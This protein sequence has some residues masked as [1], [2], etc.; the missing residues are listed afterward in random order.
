M[1]NLTLNSS[2]EE[3]EAYYPYEVW[4]DLMGFTK[5]ID[6][7][8]T[9]VQP[10]I[11]VCGFLMNLISFRVLFGLQFK[12]IRLFKYLKVYILNSMAVC[13]ISMFI[14]LSTM[15][16]INFNSYLSIGYT[17]YIYVIIVNTGYFY[18]CLLDILIILEQILTL[19]NKINIVN[20]YS[21]F[22]FCLMAF[23]LCLLINLPY[24]FVFKPA[25]LSVNLSESVSQIFYFVG[26]N[27]FSKSA[28]GKILILAVYLIRDFVT[29]AFEIILNLMSMVMLRKHL[30][31][32]SVLTA[33]FSLVEGR[34]VSKDTMSVLTKN[35]AQSTSNKKRMT[36]MDKNEKKSIFNAK[37]SDTEINS[38]VTMMVIAI[39]ILSTLQHLFLFIGLMNNYFNPSEISLSVLAFAD[40]F[41]T[42]KHSSNLALFM[43]FNKR[44]KKNFFEVF[45]NIC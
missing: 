12:S 10:S 37:S 30:T 29:L 40:T 32:K 36:M 16:Y 14:F 31:K 18:G 42:I 34:A 4:L 26:Q 15:R 22:G 28:I 39:S 6:G 21:P 17:V 24:F 44:F 20:K 41:I 35:E 2:N 19:K 8:Y 25:S 27:E 5:L 11:A 13:F 38:K 45:N 3:S 33:K 43:V 7:M 1:A 9:F 23:L